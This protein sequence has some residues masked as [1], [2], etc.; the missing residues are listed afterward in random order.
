MFTSRSWTRRRSAPDVTPFASSISNTSAGR[1]DSIT[2]ALKPGGL[3]VFV[4]YR[5]EDERVPIKPVH[6]MT[7]AQI[8]R[9]AA[10]HPLVW[11]RTVSTL[12]WQHV[13][14]FRKRD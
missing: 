14:I 3:L 1:L 6:K 7:E 5:A 10:V 2:R 13:V 9:E 12:P 11:D 4:E 8:K